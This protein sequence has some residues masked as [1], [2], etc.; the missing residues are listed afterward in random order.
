MKLLL[1]SLVVLVCVACA[2][3][4]APETPA[5]APVAVPD[6]TGNWTGSPQGYIEGI[7][8]I[9]SSGTIAMRITG[10]QGR[11]FNGTISIVEA[12]GS[13]STRYIAGAIGRDNRSFTVV[14]SDTGYDIGTIVSDNEIELVYVSD[15]DPV[16]VVIDSFVRSA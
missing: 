2:G 1:V 7:G 5:S 14:Q 8:Y 15:K 12:N 9:G 3:C 6:L 11:I 13:I 10:Q 4:T 16:K